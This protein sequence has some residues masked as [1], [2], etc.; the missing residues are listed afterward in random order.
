[1]HHMNS[2][3]ISSFWEYEQ[4]RSASSDNPTLLRIRDIFHHF[5]KPRLTSRRRDWDNLSDDRFY[6]DPDA[7]PGA[8]GH[9]RNFDDGEMERAKTTNLSARE[10]VAHAS[11][12]RCRDACD[13][14]PKCFQYRWQDG[15]CGLSWSV[16]L[17]A[18]AAGGRDETTTFTSGWNTARIMRF[19]DE[20]GGCEEVRWPLVNA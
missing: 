14:E 5:V 17:G 10:E 3:E 6:L 18:P 4:H 7:P 15:L 19:L 12:E 20:M 16:K 2:E 13:E 9:G 8:P 1:M 11:W